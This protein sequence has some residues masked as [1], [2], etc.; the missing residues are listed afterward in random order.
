MISFEDYKNLVFGENISVAYWTPETNVKKVANELHELIQQEE[1]LIFSIQTNLESEKI[2]LMPIDME[3]KENRK[4]LVIMI[5][6][7]F[8][9]YELSKQERE[10]LPIPTYFMASLNKLS[11]QLRTTENKYS[12]SDELIGNYLSR[13]LPEVNT[14]GI[15]DL[16]EINPLKAVYEI[17]KHVKSGF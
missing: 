4:N 17:M 1:N 3:Q 14:V 5:N 15:F 8:N 12:N 7:K 11:Q 16:D 10:I 2:F 13:T 6:N 9:P